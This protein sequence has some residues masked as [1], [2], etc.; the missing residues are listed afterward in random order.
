MGDITARRQLEEIRLRMTFPARLSRA[1]GSLLS[2]APPACPFCDGSLAC[3]S[4]RRGRLTPS[5]RGE[6]ESI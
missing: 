5:V 2:P 1:L 3:S 6:D 4:G